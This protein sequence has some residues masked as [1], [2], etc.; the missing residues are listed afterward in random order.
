VS[1]S[2]E[3]TA[4]R[5]QEQGIIAIVRGT[6]ELPYL[7]EVAAALREGGVHTLEVTLNSKGA[8]E[9]IEALQGEGLLVGAGTVRRPEHASAAVAAG[10][11][12]LV[13]PGLSA[14]VVA[15][16]RELAVLHVPG[17]YTA[18]EVEAATALGCTLLKLFPADVGGPAHLKALRAPFEDVAFV[19]SGGVQAG[20][21]AA[22]IEAGAAAVGLGSSLIESKRQSLSQLS[23]A[24]CGF[25]ELLQSARQRMGVG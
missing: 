25:V 3:A 17:V 1:T 18:S 2:P 5:I 7:L 8:L 21:L 4:N 11:T 22:F 23:A 19:P 14:P 12:F 13:S 15:R 6:Y 24:A 20:N 10:A 16:A 9:A